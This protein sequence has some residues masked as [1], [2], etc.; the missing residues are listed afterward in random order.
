MELVAD[1][2]KHGGR[3]AAEQTLGAGGDRLEHRPCIGRG[4][5]DDFQDV[6]RCGQPFEGLPLLVGQPRFLGRAGVELLL[7]LVDPALQRGS[8]ILGKRGH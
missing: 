5:C 7:E 1:E 2:L 8:H 4:G 3:E 6:G